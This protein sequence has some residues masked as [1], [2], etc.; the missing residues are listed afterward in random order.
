[1]HENEMHRGFLELPQGHHLTVDNI[2]LRVG[3]SCGKVAKCIDEMERLG[4]FS[5]DERGCIY[6]RR[7]A[8]DTHI[9]KVRREAALA[10]QGASKRAENG[11]FLHQQNEN[12]A[13]AKRDFAPAKRD[14]APAKPPAKP[15]QNPAVTASVSVSVLNTET[16]SSASTSVAPSKIH[17]GG[18]GGAPNQEF[19]LTHAEIRKHDPAVDSAFVQALANRVVQGCISSPEFEQAK[20]P[21]INDRAIAAAVRE[22]YSTGPPDHRAGLLLSRVPAILI[23]WSTQPSAQ[24]SYERQN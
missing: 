21:K 1:M 9:S 15:Q 3:R 18:N 24:E 20:L 6:S 2:A 14:F 17:G 8:R 10:R 16:V 23:T 12:F 11:S 22:S 4:I 7:M 13:P 19:P 5:R